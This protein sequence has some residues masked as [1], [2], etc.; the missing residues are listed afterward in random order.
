MVFC[1]PLILF[2]QEASQKNASIP[3]SVQD[4]LK[5]MKLSRHGVDTL[6]A[7]DSAVI[8]DLVLE[9]GK[10]NLGMPFPDFRAISLNG[11]TYSQELLKG[12]VTFINFWF[13]HCQPC[14]A[15]FQVLNNLYNKYK[16]NKDF[17][18]ISFTFEK[19]ENAQRAAKKYRLE[20]PIICIS[21]DSCRKLINNKYSGFP[22]NLITDRE[23]KIQF[24]IIGGFSDPEV[25]KKGEKSIFIPKLEAILQSARL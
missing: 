19:P 10:E 8:P 18:F 9:Q 7:S 6:S 4:Y 21:P 16:D 15:E 20:Y 22:T 12:K 23:V 25:A 11:K 5:H 13:E 3:K 17:E 24:F 1:I 2:S 14:I